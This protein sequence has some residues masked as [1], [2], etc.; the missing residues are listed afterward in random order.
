MGSGISSDS[1]GDTQTIKAITDKCFSPSNLAALFSEYNRKTIPLNP[2]AK[3]EPLLFSIL[4]DKIVTNKF[5]QEQIEPSIYNTITDQITPFLSQVNFF[6]DRYGYAIRKLQSKLHNEPI[7]H[8]KNWQNACQSL[9]SD[10]SSAKDIPFV[11]GAIF[12]V[13]F[14]LQDEIDKVSEKDFDQ[15][16]T[17]LLNVMLTAPISDNGS[18][19][20]Q[21]IS[22]FNSYLV[23][24][25]TRN[26]FSSLSIRTKIIA[27]LLKVAE[28]D[29]GITTIISSLFVEMSIPP[30]SPIESLLLPKLEIYPQISKENFGHWKKFWNIELPAIQ[31]FTATQQNIY[32]SADYI[33]KLDIVTG[34]L[35]KLQIESKYSL[36]TNDSSQLYIFDNVKSALSIYS[37]E[38][39]TFTKDLAGILQNPNQIRSFLHFNSFIYILYQLNN[40]TTYEVE[41]YSLGDETMVCTNKGQ[42]QTPFRNCNLIAF[43]NEICLISPESKTMIPF[44]FA[45]KEISQTKHS[46]STILCPDAIYITSFGQYTYT[47]EKM[48]GN[49]RMKRFDNKFGLALTYEP[50]VK[51]QSSENI[52]G[53]VEDII[54]S[55]SYQ[56][57]N[58]IQF[59]FSKPIHEADAQ[60]KK[61][62]NFF[63]SQN[64]E[65]TLLAC[66]K[67]G[68]KCLEETEYSVHFR[69]TIL[70]FILQVL[71]VALRFFTFRFPYD[72]K[73]ETFID[74]N[75]KEIFA[76]IRRFIKTIALSDIAT[77]SIISAEFQVINA[78]FKYLYNPFYT[79]F[80]ELVNNIGKKSHEYVAAAIPFLYGSVALIYSINQNTVAILEK[81]HTPSVLA[82]L[83]SNQVPFIN[84]ELL[85]IT[86]HKYNVEH[87][88]A[89]YI[90]S[91][92]DYF[93]NILC[94]ENISI[95]P[96]DAEEFIL[97]VVARILSLNKKSSI[98]FGSFAKSILSL[99]KIFI[100]EYKQTDSVKSDDDI[101]S[102][103]LN[104]TTRVRYSSQTFETMHPYP[105]KQDKETPF[106]MCGASEIKI[107]FDPQC[108]TEAT[109]DYLQIFDKSEGG[110]SA[111]KT[112]TGPAGP[113]WPREIIIN[114]D[115]CRFLFHS[116]ESTSDWGIKCFISANVPITDS[117]ITP[118]VTIMIANL[119]C[120][121]LGWSIEQIASVDETEESLQSQIPPDH[122][123]TEEQQ[124]FLN[125]VADHNNVH[126]IVTAI[127]SNVRMFN[128][129]RN[130]TNFNDDEMDCPCIAAA[131]RQAN[132][133]SEAMNY[134]PA[135]PPKSFQDITLRLQSLKTL[136]R[137]KSQPVV[138]DIV[139]Q[140]EIA[141]DI[142][143]AIIKKAKYFVKNEFLGKTVIEFFTILRSSKP[144]SYFY[145]KNKEM[146]QYVLSVKEVP[147][148]I[149]EFLSLQNV[150]HTGK[151]AFISQL[152]KGAI[153]AAENPE[154]FDT[155]I[156]MITGNVPNSL[157]L[158]IMKTILIHRELNEKHLKQI[159]L[160]IVHFKPKEIEENVFVENMWLFILNH[161]INYNFSPEIFNLLVDFIVN[162]KSDI[163]EMTK[164][165]ITMILSLLINSNVNIDVI[166]ILKNYKVDTPRHLCS[167]LRLFCFFL[168]NSKKNLPEKIYFLDKEYNFY[169][170]IKLLFM[171]IANPII[172]KK[173]DIQE[174]QKFELQSHFF[175]SSEAIF[176]LRNLMSDPVNQDLK[177]RV[178]LVIRECLDKQEASEQLLASF[179]ILGGGMLPLSYGC[180][181]SLEDGTV[182]CVS[183]IDQQSYDVFGF[184][185]NNLEWMAVKKSR[186]MPCSIMQIPSFEFNKSNIQLFNNIHHKFSEQPSKFVSCIRCAVIASCYTLLPI[187]LQ[188]K[189]LSQEF[190]KCDDFITS[191]ISMS[192]LN[193]NT[194]KF[195]TI[196]SLISSLN[197]FLSVNSTKMSTMIDEKVIQK[198][199]EPP[200]SPPRVR[201]NSKY[202]FDDRE[203][204]NMNTVIPF[205]MMNKRHK[206]SPT[207]MVCIFGSA[208]ING[209]KFKSNVPCLY[210]GDKTLNSHINPFY[211]EIKVVQAPLYHMSIGFADTKS[212]MGFYKLTLPT[213]EMESPNG[214]SKVIGPQLHIQN[215][216]TIGVGY[217]EEKII[218]FYN[219]TKFSQS[220]DYPNFEEFTPFVLD[221]GGN[222]EYECNFGQ[223]PFMKGVLQENLF[224]CE[225][226]SLEKFT[227]KTNKFNLDSIDDDQ[228]YDKK[229]SDL[230]PIFDP[231]NEEFVRI[232]QGKSNNESK[233]PYIMKT[234]VETNISQISLN[235]PCLVY[236]I[237]IKPSE[238]NQN[239]AI[240][241]PNINRWM[242]NRMGIVTG[243]TS[244]AYNS[245]DIALEFYNP[246]TAV[247]EKAVINSRF[248]TKVDRER[249]IGSD[250]MNKMNTESTASEALY[251]TRK[252]AIRSSRYALL[253]MIYNNPELIVKLWSSVKKKL[254]SLFSVLTIELNTFTQH[255]E[256]NPFIVDSSKF[257]PM[258]VLISEKLK[259]LLGKTNLLIFNDSSL[260]WF[261]SVIMKLAIHG[262]DGSKMADSSN[263]L[264]ENTKS[265]YK[266]NTP[267]NTG[268][269]TIDLTLEEQNAVGFVVAVHSENN[270]Q[271]SYVY[272]NE[273]DITSLA[274]DVKFLTGNKLHIKG[275]GSINNRRK[276]KF[277]VL[278][279]QSHMSEQ[280]SKTP[281]G[282]FHILLTT[283]SYYFSFLEKCPMKD[284]R[285]D[286]KEFLP[287]A[288]KL[289][290][291]D[292]LI[293][294]LVAF[295]IIAPILSRLD[296]SED[297]DA[298]ST[299]SDVSNYMTSFEASINQN[300]FLTPSAEQAILLNIMLDL[301]RLYSAEKAAAR[302]KTKI[303]QYFQM[304]MDRATNKPQTKFDTISAYFT[305]A[306]ALT[307]DWSFPIR[308]PSFL[309]IEDFLKQMPFTP[310]TLKSDDFS[311]DG[312]CLVYNF[313]NENWD[314]AE[315][316]LKNIFTVAVNG[317]DVKSG[318]VI[319]S[320][321]RITIHADKK[322]FE[323]V[324]KMKFPKYEEGLAF[325]T[326]KFNEFLQIC[327]VMRSKWTPKM[328]EELLKILRSINSDEIASELADEDYAR[329]QLLSAI[330]QKYVNV[331]ISLVKQLDSIMEY[332]LKKVD[333]KTSGLL[334]GGL[335]AARTAIATRHKQGIFKERVSNNLK[336]NNRLHLRFNRSR[337]ILHMNRPDHP[338]ASTLL[339]QLI[340][341]VPLRLIDSLKRD[342]VPWHVDL[343]GEGALDAG[344]PSRDIFSQ[345]CIELFHPSTGLFISSPNT[346]YLP[347]NAQNVDRFVPNPSCTDLVQ[348]EYAGVLMSIAYVSRMPQPFRF[349]EFVWRFLTG[350]QLTIEDI[351]SVD[352]AFASSI[353]A[354]K[355]NPA[356]TLLAHEYSFTV[357]NVAGQV[358]ELIP[359]GSSV[360]VTME[361][362]QKYV[363][364]CKEYRIKELLPHLTSLRRG[365]LHFLPTD[366]VTLLSS[367]ELELF[368]SGDTNVS[369]DELKKCCKYDAMD[370]SSIM[371]WKVIESFTPNERMLFI[372]FATGRMGLPSPGMSWHSSLTITW[373]PLQGRTD[374]NAELPTAQTCSSTIKIPRYTT[375][376]SMA[377]KIRTAIFY[378]GEIVNDRT[379]NA[380]DIVQLS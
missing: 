367:W 315:I 111:Y 121:A 54:L 294:R 340:E 178:S 180:Y 284:V 142:R 262:L 96:Q 258:T 38:N 330:P 155:L 297:E 66:L 7:E 306:T 277:A 98:I 236:R 133:V 149:Q 237:R 308:F 172:Q 198:E 9:N 215:G 52:S 342:S 300:D 358:K 60:A 278:P 240:N 244:S 77:D 230:L 301:N 158:F 281:V 92:I 350:H 311:V 299:N 80:T 104:G 123:L 194:E 333:I 272:L 167:V 68:W 83:F 295:E 114:S 249:Y 89:N 164:Y 134:D 210:V 206:E 156:N 25:A 34:N 239:E 218:F 182:F 372:K 361:N 255:V 290:M 120:F 184:N 282:S 78:G 359:Y 136:L 118:M 27:F 33:Y 94:F 322:D 227:Y 24:N 21:L 241:I 371:L 228:N 214:F 233:T 19:N 188:N 253:V 43:N 44:A 221:S 61:A 335:L 293:S 271:P 110:S 30:E 174:F 135:K 119:L 279:I 153:I 260:H 283:L 234:P 257:V 139:K 22:K 202:S 86:G 276:L 185:V 251:Y 26:V 226:F 259:E 67:L 238:A 307:H 58:L 41:E 252:I 346:Q 327:D 324:I 229:V 55:L 366:A 250:F 254:S 64:P 298:F 124:E 197:Y 193:T 37:L 323:I 231:P 334:A 97:Q 102:H 349:A 13:F 339:R 192:P 337:A 144:L 365:I 305:H 222:G 196:P 105:A 355:E 10:K 379:Q 85:F 224:G 145:E 90:S 35:E 3:V 274:R 168:K 267:A 261:F 152:K 31:S 93:S 213:N 269:F 245:S 270:I 62:V 106:E 125:K 190:E 377:K 345:M 338:S 313:T 331:R 79:D 141:G 216:D 1:S 205:S 65:E 191:L 200:I 189:K 263:N 179:V 291:S 319:T 5:T 235:G 336:D 176:C 59:L 75:A 211:F 201:S 195:E 128:N 347:R 101:L 140:E 87:V 148:M 15:V 356:K 288:V 318:T 36:I 11:L 264:Y 48:S 354:F 289:M 199:I 45:N 329:S 47:L 50:L 325:F 113:G 320:P 362:V 151:I 344:G 208:E 266:F 56:L 122:P 116:E 159:L 76:K 20:P 332:L 248:I 63:I 127:R 310:V 161:L 304:L 243:I 109:T 82:N 183:E 147:Q 303:P 72:S 69:Q 376:E 126:P 88:L 374:E 207:K 117:Y 46:P 302:D 256:I 316:I 32:F 280:C 380:A 232:E 314:S 23:S 357:V 70:L 351:Y 29:G 364:L 17:N 143:K 360:K 49:Y 157:R 369:V 4:I 312:K 170:F 146:K 373:L 51:Q 74:G 375:E 204:K 115:T 130:Q 223:V 343:I 108:A 275:N 217:S 186:L 286:L 285:A 166:S 187:I 177:K 81:Y 137:Q 40:Q 348:L 287:M 28:I 175:I 8:E 42:I 181:S 353:K 268:N 341:Q 100:K 99:L 326:S 317:K 328:D 71:V 73:D 352:S 6:A 246:A 292:G 368:V 265:Y 2:E 273:N 84:N 18:I 39:Y 169:S 132:L 171:F 165:K 247:K 220:I 150:F 57:I 363:K 14:G 131:F 16:L 163:S 162:E 370:K 242:Y 209:R 219:G 378:G 225:R 203:V 91:I 103:P 173:I 154:T 309:L 112:L 107:E 129:K 160:F 95:R 321:S 296:W 53:F 12:S 138:G 212:P